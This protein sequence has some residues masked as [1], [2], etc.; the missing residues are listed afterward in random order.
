MIRIPSYQESQV[1]LFP[2]FLLQCQDQDTIPC[3]LQFHHHIHSKAAERIYRRTGFSLCHWSTYS[4]IV[5]THSP[6]VIPFHLGLLYNQ[7]SFVQGSFI[8]LLMETVRTSE[9]SVNIYL[10]TRQYIPE[11]SK[12]H[13]RLRENLSQIFTLLATLNK[14]LH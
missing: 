12:L 8:A 3:F 13:T 11:D 10:T 9:M 6:L 7:L 4:P 1:P 2:T 5:F 14:V